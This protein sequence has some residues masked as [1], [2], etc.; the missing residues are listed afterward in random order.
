MTAAP[1]RPCGGHQ[2]AR[3]HRPRLVPRQAG[4]RERPAH[5]AG[6]KTGDSKACS[7]FVEACSRFVSGG[8]TFVGTGK[9]PADS[10]R[11]DLRVCP[12]PFDRHRHRD[13]RRREEQ[14]LGHRRRLQV[15]HVWIQC[16][17]RGAGGRGGRRSGQRQHDPADGT[18][19]DREGG[20]RD[21]DARRAGSIE[22]I[23][24]DRDR[25][26]QMGQRQPD[27]ADLL[28]TRRN[29]VDDPARDDEVPA[30]VVVGERQAELMI[31]PRDDRAAER[32]HER[33]RHRQRPRRERY[34]HPLILWG[35]S[36]AGS[37]GSR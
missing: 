30:R 1:P 21:R 11:A 7:S 3:G 18:G 15:Q 9:D 19:R 23:D 4:E 35:E 17:H 25:V 16:E 5:M 34:N 22:Q 37:A 36:S 20:D 28:P 27:R 24:L 29:A 26:Q 32:R 31:M 14:R 33:S 8:G 6:L 10:S 2:R 13:G 12:T